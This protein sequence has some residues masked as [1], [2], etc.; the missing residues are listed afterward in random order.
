MFSEIHRDIADTERYSQEQAT[1]LLLKELRDSS[2]PQWFEIF[3]QALA[4]E[5]N[6][7]V[8]LSSLN[9]LFNRQ[10]SSHMH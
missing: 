8:H 5:R 9:L 10:T 3:K 1:K 6:V 4:K 2:N 7:F